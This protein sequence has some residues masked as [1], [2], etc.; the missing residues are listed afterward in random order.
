VAENSSGSGKIWKI[1]GLVAGLIAVPAYALLA[2]NFV[3]TEDNKMTIIQQGEK[4]TDMEWALSKDLVDIRRDETDLKLNQTEM[5]AR[6]DDLIGTI[7]EIKAQ[8][9]AASGRGKK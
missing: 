3:T 6:I 9:G 1:A 2:W 4:L 7:N 8:L 5:Q